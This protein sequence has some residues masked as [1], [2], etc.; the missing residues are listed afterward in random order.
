MP[1][2]PIV[3]LF[4]MDAILVAIGLE[5][6]FVNKC[7]LCNV[8]VSLLASLTKAVRPKINIFH[9]TRRTLY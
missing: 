2:N 1:N 9:N 4:V 3:T 8:T 7:G 6:C 5:Y